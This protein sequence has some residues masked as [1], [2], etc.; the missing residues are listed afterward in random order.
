VAAVSRE[1]R[2]WIAGLLLAGGGVLLALEVALGVAL[3]GWPE[4]P[5]EDLPGQQLDETTPATGAAGDA[6]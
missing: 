1:R 2:T 3:A 4:P 5:F 6:P